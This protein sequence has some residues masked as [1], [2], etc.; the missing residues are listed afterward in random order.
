[1]NVLVTGGSGKLA[2][3]VVREFSDQQV[4]LMDTREPPDDRSHLRFLQGDLTNMDD[5][6]RV[7]AASKP[8][9][10]VALG[11][12]PSPTDREK[13]VDRK[14]GPRPFDTTM[15]VNVMGLYYLMTAAAE[16]GVG[17]VI[18]TSS[19]VT[20]IGRGT[21]YQYLP[22][23]DSHPGCATDS[24]IY[25]KMAGELMLQW[26]SNTHGIKTHCCRSAWIWTPEELEEHAQN[27]CPAEGWEESSLWYYV[28]IR[29]VARAHR[30]I[31]DALDRLPP[32]DRYL[33]TA[34][35]HRAQED[36][37]ELVEKFRPELANTIPINLNGRQSFASCKK[38]GNAFGYK[39]LFSWTDWL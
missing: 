20:I 37:R 26:F 1:M 6:R 39:P 9:V 22:V 4:F 10:I 31:F 17:A 7:I 23:D 30:L 28:D 16:A 29:D 19:I 15:Q 33:I 21:E 32:H 3:Y 13:E 25:S 36:S 18:Q 2:G 27:I 38:A 14:E 8:T 34:A 11:A 12:I 24:Y 35:D 5:C